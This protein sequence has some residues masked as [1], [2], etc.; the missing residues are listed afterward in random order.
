M[1][2]L[3]HTDTELFDDC[4]EYD[5]V[6]VY[7]KNGNSFFLAKRNY[8]DGVCSCCSNSD[9]SEDIEKVEYYTVKE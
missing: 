9:L 1:F 2:H 4:E 5:V 6:I 8:A 7:L 3:M